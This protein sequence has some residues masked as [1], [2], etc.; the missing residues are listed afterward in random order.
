MSVMKTIDIC[1]DHQGCVRMFS[2]S[3]ENAKV[4]RL[5]AW[6]VDWNRRKVDGRMVDLCPTHSRP[7]STSGRA[8]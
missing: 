2:S 5:W 7:Y 6:G 3:A 4:A 1:C 8:S